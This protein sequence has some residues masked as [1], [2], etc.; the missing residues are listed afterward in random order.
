MTGLSD[1]LHAKGRPGNNRAAFCIVVHP[2]RSGREGFIM[3]LT[4]ILILVLILILIG[5]V[6][7]WPYET[8]ARVV[9]AWALFR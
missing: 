1:S 3:A 7:N 9:L 5:A 8:C 2:N 6:P 4:T